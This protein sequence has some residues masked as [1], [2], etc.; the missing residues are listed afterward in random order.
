M[1]VG[2]VTILKGEKNILWDMYKACTLMSIKM[3]LKFHGIQ[4]FIEMT[5]GF[6]NKEIQLFY[7]LLTNNIISSFFNGG[8]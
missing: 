3:A 4:C 8:I 2:S 5:K 6:K 1:T 7:Y